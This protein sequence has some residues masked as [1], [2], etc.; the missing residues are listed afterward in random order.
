M[1]GCG[2]SCFRATQCLRLSCHLLA[3]QTPPRPIGQEIKVRGLELLFDEKFP[4]PAL[5]LP[6]RRMLSEGGR[7]NPSARFPRFGR[8]GL[9]TR[10]EPPGAL[11]PHRFI[12]D[13]S[14]T[15]LLNRSNPHISYSS[16]KRET[17]TPYQA[18]MRVRF[19]P[20]PV[21]QQPLFLLATVCRMKWIENQNLIA[22]VPSTKAR[23]FLAG[24]AYAP[25][26]MKYPG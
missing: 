26:A 19:K 11:R 18:P 10:C 17:R 20:R 24:Y 4:H 25:Q 23:L 3:A 5:S 21:P 14:A 9:R 13:F 15:V 6:L 16:F 22:T 7:G 12:A 1:G 8:G 2:A